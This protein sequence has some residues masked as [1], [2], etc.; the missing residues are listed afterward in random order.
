[1]Q[2]HNRLGA[3]KFSRGDIDGAHYH[4]QNSTRL[5]P[6]LGETHNNLGTT[7]SARAQMFAQQG[8][9]AAASREM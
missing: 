1:M 9:Q 4:F 3:R 2:A 5:R 8:D 6:D 7:L